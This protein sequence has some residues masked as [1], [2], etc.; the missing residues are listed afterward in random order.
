VG[1]LVFIDFSNPDHPQVEKLSYDL[2]GYTICVID[3]GADH[4]GLTDDYAAIRNEMVRVAAFF[5][6]TV[7]NDVE[8]PAF[9]AHIGRLRSEVGER[10]VLR[11]FHF[12]RENERVKA[13]KAALAAQDTP[14]FMA[15]VKESGQSSYM[16]L[17]NVLRSVEKQELAICL[18]FCDKL[19]GRKG[20]FRVQGGG[21]AG[22][23]E[24][25]VPDDMLK[26][27][28]SG[29]EALLGKGCCHT[30]QLRKHGAVRLV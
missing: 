2:H 22:T 8:E 9:F 27:F 14:Q 20:A 18:A 6:K 23:I 30:I 16:Y 25:F 1:G 26:S 19:L 3:S 15:L 29:M 24:A 17:Q 5:G 28:Q 4:A 13:Q 10:A 12:F 21:F 7:L 11:A